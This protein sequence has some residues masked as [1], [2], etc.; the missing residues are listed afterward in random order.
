MKKKSKR[1]LAVLASIF[2][3]VAAGCLI[4]YCLDRINN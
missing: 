1:I 3:I 4:A 2:V